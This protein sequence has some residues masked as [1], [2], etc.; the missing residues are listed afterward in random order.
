[1]LPRYVGAACDL[2]VDAAGDDEVSS[3]LATLLHAFE[4]ELR[5]VRAD[6]GLD[7][8]AASVPT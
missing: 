4:T 1:V 8:I 5:Q 6:L 7:A 2:I 3:G